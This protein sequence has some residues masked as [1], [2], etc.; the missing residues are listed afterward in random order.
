MYRRL[1]SVYVITPRALMAGLMN[2]RI[3]IAQ[4]VFRKEIIIKW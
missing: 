2:T 4:N 3:L 1:N